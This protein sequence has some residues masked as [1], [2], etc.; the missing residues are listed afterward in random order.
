[1]AQVSAALG[2]T[3]E[4]LLDEALRQ[5]SKQLNE[6]GCPSWW[7]K[8]LPRHQEEMPLKTSA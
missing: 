3:D 7:N 5:L 1:M 6:N 2:V 8:P 4:Y